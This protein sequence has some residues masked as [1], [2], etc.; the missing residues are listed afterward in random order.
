MESERERREYPDAHPKVLRAFERR[1]E[2]RES[3]P[4][5]TAVVAG[6]GPFS[7]GKIWSYLGGV[8]IKTKKIGEL[9]APK[10]LVVGREWVEGFERQEVGR[11]LRERQGKV[12]RIC[13]QEMLLAW[14]MTGTDPNRQFQSAETFIE[15]H[16]ALERIEKLLKDRWPGTDVIPSDGGGDEGF[17]RPDKSPLKRL[18]YSVGRSGESRST[19]QDAIHKTYTTER[20]ALPGEYSAEYRRQWGP[21]ESGV[22]LKRIADHIASNCRSRK[23][24]DR[25]LDLA[26]EHWESDLRWLKK[27]YYI[28]LT[29]GFQWPEATE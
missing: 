13:S 3:A 10:L 11:L 29:Y 24:S 12:L 16:P 14:A 18:G 6:K 21:A 23:G 25:D 28:P 4:V 27:E 8:G 22:R 15:G 19:R 7:R 9:E 2:E 26:I 20:D 5:E 17:S 1:W